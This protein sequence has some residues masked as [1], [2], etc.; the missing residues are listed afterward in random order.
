ML[1]QA[2]ESDGD[3]AETL[4]HNTNELIGYYNLDPNRVLDLILEALEQLIHQS[5]DHDGSLES[6]KV[7]YL[8][9]IDEIC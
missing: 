9:L 2:Y 7:M 6:F 3:S 4:R 1:N 5:Q 8:P